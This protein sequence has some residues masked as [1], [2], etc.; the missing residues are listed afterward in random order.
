MSDDLN[1]IVEE[2]AA[3]KETA[4]A[5]LN[6]YKYGTT[7][8]DKAAKGYKMADRLGEIPPATEEA[9]S[10]M[11]RRYAKSLGVDYFGSP[12]VRRMLADDRLSRLVA[13]SPKEWED[14]TAW[15]IT[16]DGALSGILGAEEKWNQFVANYQSAWKAPVT[17]IGSTLSGDDA[18]AAALA[19]L[20]LDFDKIARRAQ[21]AAPG[22]LFMSRFDARPDY[23]QERDRDQRRFAFQMAESTYQRQF[24]TTPDLSAVS[25]ANTLS[26]AI[27]AALNDPLASIWYTGVQSIF[28]SPVEMVAGGVASAFN[29]LLGAMIMGSGSY[30]TEYSN[31][32][33]S[34]LEEEG[35]DMMDGEAIYKALKDPGI[36]HR[37]E[38]KAAARSLA[39][40]TF[41]T[42]SGFA[43]GVS[44][45]PVSKAMA[46]RRVKPSKMAEATT[47]AVDDIAATAGVTAEGGKA[48]VQNLKGRARDFVET[49]QSDA[50]TKQAAFGVAENLTWQTLIGGALGAAGEGAGQLA[51][52]EELNIGDMVLEALAEGFTAPVEVMTMRSEVMREAF[53]DRVA[54]MNAHDAK[55]AMD[56]TAEYQDKSVLNR[57]DPNGFVNTIQSKVEG[58]K[59]EE[60]SFSAQEVKGFAQDLI[61]A[62][63]MIAAQ[64]QEAEVTGGDIV[65]PFG[66][67][68]RIRAQN[69]QVYD[70]IAE[71]VRTDRSGMSFIEAV[72]YDQKSGTN[73]QASVE[74][75]ADTAVQT[76][77]RETR[78]TNAA[79]RALQPLRDQLRSTGASREEVSTAI[80]LEAAILENLASMAGVTVEE[81]M[82]ANPVMVQRINEKR[83]RG[84]NQSGFDQISDEQRK[85][86][87]QTN[88]E[89]LESRRGNFDPGTKTITL[90]SEADESTFIHEMAHYWLDAMVQHAI[91]TGGILPEPRVKD[92]DGD[93]IPVPNQEGRKLNQLLADFFTWADAPGM[94]EGGLQEALK[95][96]QEGGEDAQRDV[97]EKFARGFET[98]L[99][100]G[101]A[102]SERWSGIFKRFAAWLKRAYKN[103]AALGV[104]MS[105]EVVDLYNRL[106]VSEQAVID[107]KIRMGDVG[108]YDDL[109]KSGVSPEDFRF[110]VDQRNDA[111]EASE[112]YL[113][114]A[115]QRDA[116]LSRSR[117]EQEK[118]GLRK[119]YKAMVEAE[120]EALDA[121]DNFRALNAL[122][123][124]GVTGQ[125]GTVYHYKLIPS[126]IEGSVKKGNATWLRKRGM[127]ADE[128]TDSSVIQIDIAAFAKLFGFDSPDDVVNAM[129][130]ASSTHVQKAAE[131]RAAQK[132]KAQYGEVPDAQGIERAA[133]VAVQ[134]AAALDVLVTE[135]TALRKALGNRR[136]FKEAVLAFV[137]QAIGRK[138]LGITVQ[139]RNGDLVT[140]LLSPAAYRAA[141]D[142][143]GRKAFKAF[144]EGDAQRAAEAKQAQVIQTALANEVDAVNAEIE[145][146]RKRVRAALKSETIQGE[147]LVQ[148]HKLARAMGF[149]G[150]KPFTASRDISLDVFVKGNPNQNVDAHLDML[151]PYSYLPDSLFSDDGQTFIPRQIEE[152]TVDEFRAVDNLMKS[153]IKN[154]RGV[155]SS[156]AMDQRKTAAEILDGAKAQINA[157]AKSGNL[158][159]KEVQDDDGLRFGQEGKRTIAH[160]LFSHIAFPKLCQIVDGNKQGFWTQ[161]IVWGANDCGNREA[162]LLKEYGERLN[163][164]LSALYRGLNKDLVEYNGVRYTKQQVASIMLN[165]GN[166]TNMDRLFSGHGFTMNDVANFAKF[167]T[168]DEILAIQ[169]VWDLFEDLRKLSAE[170]E[171]RV[172]GFEPEWE[173]PVPFSVI[174]REGEIVRLKGG[175]CPIAYSGNASARGASLGKQDVTDAESAVAY[176]AAQTSRTYT[177]ERQ[178]HVDPN[179]KIRLDLR[180]ITD[181]MNE[182]IH[183]VCWGEYLVDFNRLWRGVTTGQGE[184]AVKHLG[185]SDLL[186]EHFGRAGMD[187]GDE[188]IKAIALNGNSTPEAASAITAKARRYV[189]V[190]GL[191]FNLV[192]SLVQVT[193]LITSS[194]RLGVRGVIRGLS[195]FAKDPRGN[196]ASVN[197]RSEFMRNRTN[198]RNREIYEVQTV[199]GGKSNLA[200]EYER[201]AYAVMMKVQAVVDYATWNAAFN[202]AMAKGLT[203]IQAA[204]YAD[205]EVINTQGS[206]MIKDRSA[207][208]NMGTFGQVFLSF[209]SFMGTAYNLGAMSLMG[210]TSSAKRW[211]Q[212]STVFFVMPILEALLRDALKIDGDDDEDKTMA[213]WARFIVAQ[214]IGFSLGTVFLLRE[215]TSLQNLVS[216]EPMYG[217][218]GPSGLRVIQD[219]H[220]LGQQI[221]QGELDEGFVRSLMNVAGTFTGLPSAQMW[222]MWTGIDAYFIE[223]KTDNPLV[224]G[225]GYSG[226]R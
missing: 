42:L 140:R 162:T 27:S 149:K 117:R 145:S 40:A 142:R 85:A 137:R 139:N 212:I 129:K 121:L 9:Y 37:A 215:L 192:S 17:D 223:D 54:S 58:T 214:P 65:I 105:P 112:A 62:S 147:Y 50:F 51:S 146:F 32:F 203:D 89:G 151:S 153:L 159:W 167:L 15:E 108:V 180:C 189:S 59:F 78:D 90:F 119:Q 226:D 76:A 75:L 102:P 176:M 204:K 31:T 10:D 150:T 106:F 12:T 154:G 70:A 132:F 114:G 20:D 43:A 211:A 191:G 82:A 155:M 101:K 186:F 103:I 44:M 61:Q 94:R 144:T 53:T 207:I 71:H 73:L 217:W 127:L 28:S 120:R 160:F 5:G 22:S 141:A 182:V 201:L 109:I 168:K 21:E 67:L 16:V 79:Y 213:E 83:M 60:V 216:G 86:D 100:T 220:N 199:L 66:E 96:W 46:L 113:R 187:V 77:E 39:V 2:I 171:R 125:D 172:N 165:A 41:D 63:P 200:L 29:P 124:K 224:L 126:S 219:I 87:S 135:A 156:R 30:S 74:R 198:T 205:Q 81:W 166:Q 8:G 45:K 221:Q 175:Y 128:T 111:R 193:G 122:K 7:N 194:S 36:R 104:D 183:D 148:I 69:K 184:N 25:E 23:S 38:Q 157:T 136:E 169:K 11:E 84:F 179:L 208:E 158:G 138:P 116:M 222:R 99:Y 34:V 134:N 133:S 33:R 210:E 130:E 164:T 47:D 161:H 48:V 173:I 152:M 92:A 188:W 185:L 177:K 72:E 3:E 95:R 209:Y 93:T 115:M 110:Y 88:K 118:R 190:A 163:T 178:K 52:G 123:D 196:I 14:A 64:W 13:D 18:D 26:E 131:E 49:M 202:E 174:S 206:G 55:T 170:K 19:A 4:T 35:V 57:R 143:A 181:G 68:Y 98:Y 24:L 225:I 56:A 80:G 6:L 195:D 1:Q 197:A 218:R 97:Q 107:A 91:A